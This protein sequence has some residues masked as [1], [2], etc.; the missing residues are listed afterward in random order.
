MILEYREEFKCLHLK[1][2]RGVDHEE[3]QVTNF[4]TIDHSLD[5]VWTFEKSDSSVFVC[6]DCD[7]SIDSVELLFCVMV[8]Q[9][10]D[11]S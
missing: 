5:V 2:N 4:G 7:C 1:P 9:G 6:T 3:S 10:F 11:E 8:N